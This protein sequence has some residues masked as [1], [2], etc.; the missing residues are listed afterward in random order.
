MELLVVIAIIGILSALLLSALSMAKASAR[1]ASCKNHLRQMG[2]GLLMY[3][4]EHRGRFPY[5]D[6]TPD[7]A[8]DASA[9]VKNTP[10]WSAKLLPYYPLKWTEPAYHC[11]AY[12]GAIAWCGGPTVP[13]GSYAYNCYGVGRKGRP[14]DRQELGL[15]GWVT[16]PSRHEPTAEFQLQVPSEMFAIGESRWKD[17]RRWGWGTAGGHDRMLCG[18]FN[19]WGADAFDPAR[20]GK[21]YNQ[22]FCDGH[23]SEMSPWIL[24]NPTNTAAMWNYDHQQHPESWPRW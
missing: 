16:M 13:F 11:P 22:L 21:K 2:F 3:V 17:Q 24:F 6:G 7:P 10:H 19:R 8:L 12:K 5:Y 23:V 9:G 14:A 1:S 4:D 18:Q 20:H 15:G